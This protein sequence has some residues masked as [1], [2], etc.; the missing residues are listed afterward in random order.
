[1]R[2][3]ARAHHSLY[4]ATAWCR[5]VQLLARRVLRHFCV[6]VAALGC[7]RGLVKRLTTHMYTLQ[8]CPSPALTARPAMSAAHSASLAAVHFMGNTIAECHDGCCALCVLI[9]HRSVMRVV[10]NDPR[11]LDSTANQVKVGPA[12][13]CG[14]GCRVIS[15]K[16]RTSTR[17]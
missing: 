14:K 5:C 3:G 4:G 11:C 16:A 7:G 13:C 12:T 15:R 17:L 6:V 9:D 8:A 2:E 1:M 10:L